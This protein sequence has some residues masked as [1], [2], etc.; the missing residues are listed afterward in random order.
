VDHWF[1]V[2]MWWL[3]ILLF[4]YMRD[5]TIESG[6]R[7]SCVYRIKYEIEDLM[8]VLLKKYII[9]Y[10]PYITHPIGVSTIHLLPR[11]IIIMIRLKISNHLHFFIPLSCIAM[12]LIIYL[13]ISMSLYKKFQMKINPDNNNKNTQLVQS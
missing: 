12:I 8:L 1:P 6:D 9:S 13:V 3:P 2:T 4:K 7:C 5:V 11:T 10:S